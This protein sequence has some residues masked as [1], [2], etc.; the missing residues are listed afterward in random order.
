[1]GT[2][3]F[4]WKFCGWNATTNGAT[5]SYGHEAYLDHAV[6]ML[7]P[8]LKPV[9][10]QPNC[11]ESMQVYEEHRIMA[12][13][14]LAMQKQLDDMR[15]IK[16]DLEEKLRQS[17]TQMDEL[18]SKSDNEQVKKFVQQ[19]KEKDSLMQFRDKLTTQLQMIKKAQTQQDQQET[20]TLD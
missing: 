19:Q 16:A 13:D 2:G 7:D 6:E 18:A 20:K 14:Y 1:M 11:P 3:K 4:L 12:A 9:P 15:N 8:D 17:E 10:P 5:P